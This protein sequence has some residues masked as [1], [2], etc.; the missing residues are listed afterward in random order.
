MAYRILGLDGG[1]TWALIEVKALI[2]IFGSDQVRGHAV[3]RMFDLVAAN[4]GG[5]I[6]LG[7]LVED[8]TLAEMLGFLLDQQKRE[9]MFSPT[10]HLLDKLLEATLGFGP[11][12][13]ADAKLV[14]LEG[15][16]PKR[17]ARPIAGITADIPGQSGAPVRLMI[18]G[19]DYDFNR[20]GFF[21][22]VAPGGPALGVAVSPDITL[23]EAIHASTN[24]PVQ[25]FDAPARFPEHGERYW[26]GGITGFNNPVLAAVTEAL[27]LGVRPSEIEALSLGTGTVHLPP[28]PKGQASSAFV[29]GWQETGLKNDLGKMAGAILDDPPDA[30]SFIAH[31]VTAG[32]VLPAPAVSRVVRMSPL[33]SPVMADGALAA[34]GAMT[35]A[36]F[37]ALCNID[38]DAVKAADVAAISAY[39]DLWLAGQAPNQMLH[40]DGLCVAQKDADGVIAPALVAVPNPLPDHGTPKPEQALGYVTFAAARAAWRALAG[41]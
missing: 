40:A 3:L 39:A 4:S 24:A 32:G 12:Y 35:P 36:A 34:P 19:F 26:D 41:W 27:S 33:V 25:Y 7:G 22:S 6:V 18:V 14:A 8:L 20:A 9:A 11:K 15:L 10:D 5:S 1:G 2:E 13:S 31:A 21:R 30:G 29:Q 16:M 38:M 28:A 37:Q 23:A 17:G